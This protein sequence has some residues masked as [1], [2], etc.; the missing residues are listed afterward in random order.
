MKKSTI[1]TL[2]VV[3]GLAGIVA[4]ARYLDLVKVIMVMHG[5]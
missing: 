5:Q 4:L 2:A 1:V 3:A